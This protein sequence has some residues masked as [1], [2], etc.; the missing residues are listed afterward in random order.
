LKRPAAMPMAEFAVALIL[1]ALAIWVLPKGTPNHGVAWVVG[2]A[3]LIVGASVV[4][5]AEQRVLFDLVVPLLGGGGT[6]LG[7][8]GALGRDRSPPPR[9]A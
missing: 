8:L 2:G 4:G 3:F 6:A 5:F 1:A 7:C 9:P